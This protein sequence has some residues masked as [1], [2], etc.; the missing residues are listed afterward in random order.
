MT[1][2]ERERPAAVTPLR[3][4][5][6][7]L[8][9]VAWL[10]V[11]V[12]SIG[13]FAASV[14]QYYRT[15]VVTLRSLD[16]DNPE[17]VR[18][19]L[20]QLGISINVYAWWVLAVLI[21][22][23]AVFAAVG[24]VIFWRKPDDPAALF[25]S[26]TLVTFGAIWPNSLDSLVARYPSL[27]LA[28]KAIGVWGFGSFFLLF[29]L[30]P[31]GRFVP[32]WTRWPAAAWML[33]TAVVTFFSDSPLS[34]ERAPPWFVLLQIVMFPGSMLFAQIYRYRRVSSR[35][36]RQQTR[37]VMYSLLL[38]LAGFIGTGMLGQIAGIDQPGV[39]AALYALGSSVTYGLAFMLV[40]ISIG[41]AILRSRLWDIDIIINR[42]LVYAMLTTCVV[43]LYVLTVGYLGAL[44]RAEE[45]LLFSLLATGL[46]AVVFQ[47]LREWLQRGVNRLMYGH[48]DEPYA[49][50]SRLGQRLEATLAPD[51]VLPAIVQAVR[52]ALRLPFAAIQ[53]Q[54]G[55]SLVLAAST[56][57]QPRDV[58]H[59]PLTYTGEAVGELVL[60][61]RPGEQEF[62]ADD[63]RLLEDLARQAGVAVHALRLRDEAL[64]LAEDLQ[65]SRQEII[66]AR[67]EERRRL[68]R[69]L[70]DGLGPQLASLTMKAEAARDL[71]ATNPATA[72]TL[73][74]DIVEHAQES[75]VDIR[76]LVYALRPPALDDL[77]LAGA[78]QAHAAQYRRSPMQ[79]TIE[80]PE[81]PPLPAAV[82]VAA[83]RIA[84]EAITNAARH[85]EART[86]R[87]Q[88]RLE[89][90]ALW[91]EVTDD[92]RGIGPECGAGVGLAS[93]RERAAELGGSV[94]IEAR[95]EG[96]TRVR[97]RLS[98]AP[99]EHAGTE[100][101]AALQ[102]E[103]DRQWKPSAS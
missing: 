65:R 52:D 35:V 38:A 78:L 54:R 66:T 5:A 103:E 41:I 71:L 76:R 93:M 74:A 92:G 12:V 70:H 10:V 4:Y 63:R 15:E 7:V 61:V 60:G 2:T 85:A 39:P 88:L 86:C 55:S 9:R 94:E 25:F 48:R 98:L 73:L 95:P 23:V 45:N 84:L 47:P 79:V 80:A 96:G 13:M 16:V 40:P 11:T 31:D 18:V 91:L 101:A 50:I 72:G 51:A 69:D 58:T 99:V 34:D 3:G 77:G 8:A 87:V 27:D 26:L 19:G 32:R 44:F 17:A 97:A 56:G 46:V 82:E 43:G 37:W 83:Y 21:A 42:T 1:T 33:S 22:L 64:R 81:L 49:V 89:E 75:V 20:Q 29:Y 68:R 62:G 24:T 57:E 90:D 102:A 53:V 6:L 28:S 30:F 14:P 67:E 36:Q 59:L 100:A